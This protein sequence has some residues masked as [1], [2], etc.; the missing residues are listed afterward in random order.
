MRFDI[1]RTR[2]ELPVDRTDA[3][4]DQVGVLKIANPYRTVITLGDRINKA[5]AVVGMDV[6]LRVASSHFREHGSEM[7]GAERKR[8]SNSQAAT[9]VTC[10]EDRFPGYVDLGA[11]SGCIVPERRPGFCERSSAGGSRT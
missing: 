7:S 8:R 11:D 6:E 5:I 4:C 9:K 1:V 2:H 3:P 10:G